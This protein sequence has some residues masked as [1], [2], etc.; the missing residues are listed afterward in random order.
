M[1]PL[2]CIVAGGHPETQNARGDGKTLA[3]LAAH[4]RRSGKHAPEVMD[5]S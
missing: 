4:G 3:L 1:L 2:S 5:K